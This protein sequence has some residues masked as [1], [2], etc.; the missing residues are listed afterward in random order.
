MQA[1]ANIFPA[2]GCSHE[3]EPDLIIEVLST[4]KVMLQG[5]APKKVTSVTKHE[6]TSLVFQFR[7][8]RK[9]RKKELKM[10][11]MWK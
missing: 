3:V 7:R 10:L 1:C 8:A 5:D 9:Q 11:K 6:A 2:C 4:G